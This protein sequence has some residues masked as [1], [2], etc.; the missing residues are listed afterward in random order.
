MKKVIIE[1]RVNEYA[2]ILGIVTT[3]VLL[4]K[5][6]SRIELSGAIFGSVQKAAVAVGTAFLA[7]F[8][9][10]ASGGL[11]IITPIFY[12]IFGTMQG[13]SPAAIAR[14]MA[15]ASSSLDSLPHSGSVNTTFVWW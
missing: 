11:G 13:V 5:R 4:F 1:A 2:I 8:C 3:V 6:F 9:G 15:L 7:G 10:S 14:V 12:E